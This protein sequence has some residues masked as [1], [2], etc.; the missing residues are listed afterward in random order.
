[1]DDAQS[2]HASSLQIGRNGA[3]RRG[4]GFHFKILK[5]TGNEG[6]A[7]GGNLFCHHRSPRGGVEVKSRYFGFTPSIPRTYILHPF[8]TLLWTFDQLCITSVSIRTRSFNILGTRN[9]FVKALNWDRNQ[10]RSRSSAY[11]WAL[12]HRKEAINPKTSE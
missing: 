4:R 5:I 12:F 3:N 8:N 1:M 10:Q 6:W 9:M 7:K 11:L 2:C